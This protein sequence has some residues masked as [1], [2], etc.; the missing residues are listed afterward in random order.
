[1]N[2]RR[3]EEREKGQASRASGKEGEKQGNGRANGRKGN[4]EGGKDVKTCVER[5]RDRVEDR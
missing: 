5:G 4:K 3:I 2:E 1:M